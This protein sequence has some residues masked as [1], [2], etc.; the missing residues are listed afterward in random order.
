MLRQKSPEW[1]EEQI[2]S[3]VAHLCKAH[4][5]VP[6]SILRIVV[7]AASVELDS[8]AGRDRLHQHA[9]KLARDMR[10]MFQELASEQIPPR[11]GE[12]DAA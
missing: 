10:H 7:R 4:P 1:P 6:T 2:D 3:A 11:Q 9:T 12:A 8:A 5:Q